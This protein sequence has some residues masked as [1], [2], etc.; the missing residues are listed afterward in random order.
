[1]RFFRARQG[2]DRQHWAIERSI[3]RTAERDFKRGRI[4]KTYRGVK[5]YAFIN[6]PL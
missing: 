5:Y 1:M 3:N 6:L 4:R 2:Q